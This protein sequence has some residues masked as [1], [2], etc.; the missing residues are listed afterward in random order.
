MFPV[1]QDLLHFIHFFSF[2]YVWWWSDIIFFI[3]L[4]FSIKIE[5]CGMEDLVDSPK[6]PGVSTGK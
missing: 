6:T 1:L 4:V 3:N 2:F 5:Q